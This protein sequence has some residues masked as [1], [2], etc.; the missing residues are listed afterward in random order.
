MA[1]VGLAEWLG[2]TETNLER[3]QYY[4]LQYYRF[5][6]SQELVITIFVEIIWR[7]RISTIS[8]PFY[9]DVIHKDD[10]FLLSNVKLEIKAKDLSLTLMTF[11]TCFTSP[12]QQ[13]WLHKYILV[14]KNQASKMKF[15]WC[16]EIFYEF[17]FQKWV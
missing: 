5:N 12:S 9:D 4:I 8:G 3:K 15:F 7:V 13:R 2:F 17:S 10:S 6:F 14:Y 11:W 1:R 16:K